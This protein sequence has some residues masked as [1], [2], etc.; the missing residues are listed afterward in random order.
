MPLRIA[1]DGNPT[2]ALVRRVH[3]L[4]LLDL[5]HSTLCTTW[6]RI[7]QAT[8]FM[9]RSAYHSTADSY[10]AKIKNWKQP[11]SL[12]PPRKGTGASLICES[13]PERATSK[14]APKVLCSTPRD[15]DLVQS[16]PRV[17]QAQHSRSTQTSRANPNCTTQPDILQTE[18]KIQAARPYPRRRR[19]RRQRPETTIPSGSLIHAPSK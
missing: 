16:V 12:R 9:K 7:M 3:P 4:S 5:I 6:A 10:L 14:R 18:T 2:K 1:W 19:R 11:E 8:L 15:V 17:T 13:D